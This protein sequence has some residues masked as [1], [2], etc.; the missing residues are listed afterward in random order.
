[1]PIIGID[2][3]RLICHAGRKSQIFQTLS[4]VSFSPSLTVLSTYPVS[5]LK[6]IEKN[7]LAKPPPSHTA[8][9][10][11]QIFMLLPKWQHEFDNWNN[12][13][14]NEG[15][16][17]GEDPDNIVVDVLLRSTNSNDVNG[18][19]NG[20]K[21]TVEGWSASRGGPCPLVD[22]PGLEDYWS[23]KPTVHEVNMP[24]NQILNII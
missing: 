3:S 6:Y 11:W 16:S 15:V 8:E 20:V 23:T 18:L 5:L 17:R 4:D 22:L 14:R 24:N 2:Q 7:Y 12:N 21:R 13:S 10:F 19:H 1:M 9:K